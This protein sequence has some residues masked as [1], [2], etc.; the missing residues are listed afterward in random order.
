[1]VTDDQAPQLL[2]VFD[3]EMTVAP[4]VFMLPQARTL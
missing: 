4:E 1:M 3:S 2:P